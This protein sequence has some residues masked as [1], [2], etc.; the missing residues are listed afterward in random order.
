MCMIVLNTH[1]FLS[2]GINDYRRL[3]T[4]LANIMSSS[5]VHC[6]PC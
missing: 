4:S 1:G 3:Y 2:L 6:N 5:E